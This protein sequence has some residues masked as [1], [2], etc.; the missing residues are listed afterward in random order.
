MQYRIFFSKIDIFQSENSFNL[1]DA[2]W[3]SPGLLSLWSAL[4][5]LPYIRPVLVYG[6]ILRIVEVYNST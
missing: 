5:K 6:Y 4:G 3:P 2:R 1:Y